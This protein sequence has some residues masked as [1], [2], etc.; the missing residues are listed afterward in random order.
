MPQRRVHSNVASFQITRWGRGRFSSA[1]LEC[2]ISVTHSFFISSLL[3]IST[4][5]ILQPRKALPPSCSLPILRGWLYNTRHVFWDLAPRNPQI[6][7]LLTKPASLKWRPGLT[8]VS[9]HASRSCFGSQ[10]LNNVFFVLGHTLSFPRSNGI[11][12]LNEGD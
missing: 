11:L 1:H 4:N 3:Q 5:S 2:G 7:L 6:T 8:L 9:K 10:K 12:C